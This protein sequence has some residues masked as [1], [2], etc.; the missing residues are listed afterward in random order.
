MMK[1]LLLILPLALVA[2]EV[3]FGNP[4]GHL[5]DNSTGLE[6]SAEFLILQPFE[7]DLVY[8]IRNDV[9]QTSGGADG[10]PGGPLISLKTRWQ[11]GWRVMVGYSP[12]VTA[13]AIWMG[14]IGSSI[15]RAKAGIT[16]A[17]VGLQATW[18]PPVNSAILY[19]SATFQWG[20][21]LNLLDFEVGKRYWVSPHLSLNP[22]ITLRLAEIDQSFHAVY[23]LSGAEHSAHAM[24]DFRGLGPQ[25]AL[26]MAWGFAHGW[27]IFASSS[28][29]LLY[30]RFITHYGVY[31]PLGLSDVDAHFFRFVPDANTSLGIGW[32]RCL[33]KN[34][35]NLKFQLSY[36]GHL[37][38]DQTQLR[39]PIGSDAPS[40]AILQ[41]NNLSIQGFSIRGQCEF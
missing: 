41:T 26:S 11:P 39:Q 21:D 4:T 16:P 12:S 7:D 29:S 13:R 5:C 18:V 28:A 20:M 37:F 31:P 23:T 25:A 33:S 34:R 22:A 38:W 32:G 27:E 14:F 24:N 10:T 1:Q 17:G 19:Q 8:A 9:R 3:R 6:L 36:E 2:E 40:L 30:G 35:W 15:G